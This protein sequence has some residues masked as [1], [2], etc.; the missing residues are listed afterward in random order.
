M[1]D[2]LELPSRCGLNQCLGYEARVLATAAANNVS[3]HFIRRVQSYVAHHV[4]GE[5]GL[6]GMDNREL[7]TLR[8]KMAADICRAPG[9]AYRSPPAAHAWIRAQRLRLGLTDDIFHGA[10]RGEAKPLLYH[11][12]ASPSLF[13]PAMD[14]MSRELE[15]GGRKAFSL[16]PLR[17]S[18]APRHIHLDRECFIQLLPLR[19]EQ[20]EKES[21]C[22]QTAERAIPR[23]RCLVPAF[24]CTAH[25]RPPLYTLHTPHPAQVQGTPVHQARHYLKRPSGRGRRA[26][27]SQ[28]KCSLQVP[29]NT[30]RLPRI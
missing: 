19:R 28:M 18:L 3:R 24:H 5:E 6:R 26:S 27:A 30:K 15:A 22:R 12:K 17:R 1:A 10:G 23:R 11:L 13:L 29:R 16:Y 20:F 4:A 2:A 14:I 9:A 7:R 8:D 21:S 25:T